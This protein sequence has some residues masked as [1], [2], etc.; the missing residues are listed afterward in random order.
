MRI[1]KL[2]I[3]LLMA[4]LGFSFQ[5][6]SALEVS[7]VRPMIPVT[8]PAAENW[9]SMTS[10]VEMS[11]NTLV[12]AYK[13]ND[14]F[15][16]ASTDGGETWGE[17]VN[18]GSPGFWTPGVSLIKVDETHLLMT[19]RDN[20]GAYWSKIGTL[21]GNSLTFSDPTAIYTPS[22]NITLLLSSYATIV[23]SGN[24]YAYFPLVNYQTFNGESE[25]VE[26]VS[27]DMGATWTL[28]STIITYSEARMA[29][30]IKVILLEDGR[31]VIYCSLSDTG[32]NRYAMLKV[33]NGANWDLVS[34]DDE[35]LGSNMVSV[36]NGKGVALMGTGTDGHFVN[37]HIWAD[38]DESPTIANNQSDAWAG[39]QTIVSDGDSTIAIQF[40]DKM[41]PPNSYGGR[42]AEI[43][44]TK[45]L[46]ATWSTHIFETIADEVPTED[47]RLYGSFLVMGEDGGF[48][49]GYA[50]NELDQSGLTIKLST[51]LDGGESWTEPSILIDGYVLDTWGWTGPWY[52]GESPILIGTVA[53]DITNN[54]YMGVDVIKFNMPQALPDK[55]IFKSKFE[56]GKLKLTTTEK[57]DLR[58]WA[59][60]IAD[61]TSVVVTAPDYIKPDVKRKAKRSLARANL[62]AKILR[63]SGLQVTV[64]EGE[65]VKAISPQKGRTV[66]IEIPV[67]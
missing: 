39:G 52:S 38:I 7:D 19:Y 65:V 31:K 14:Y 3:G 54:Y 51:S 2:V 64:V 40:V 44:I 28:N 12:V 18:L 41:N 21:T 17:T 35:L 42:S 61:D 1:K 66:K 67:K 23:D 8:D 30:G 9:F 13:E 62:V 24:L 55:L 47:Y 53:R 22:N 49:Y 56:Y 37:T 36:N 59:D 33:S 15:A 50:T 25:L 6:A 34:D 29:N 57:A 48:L 32:N 27:T 58:A 11:K 43:L 46:G 45:D 10:L 5:S 16:K 20:S 4:S 63:N 26:Y 60:Q